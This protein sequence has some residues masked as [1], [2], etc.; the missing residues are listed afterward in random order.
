M[1]IP[2]ISNRA[3]CALVILVAAIWGVIL[4]NRFLVRDAG[5]AFHAQPR[6]LNHMRGPRN[7]HPSKTQRYQ[8]LAALDEETP[9]LST[10]SRTRLMM[11]LCRLSVRTDPAT[12]S[13]R[14]T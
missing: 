13:T 9:D 1:K 14:L 6:K 12:L 10:I 3:L 8:W 2:D 7:A 4:T 11:S 5:A